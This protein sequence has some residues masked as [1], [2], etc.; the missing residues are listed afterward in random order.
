VTIVIAVVGGAGGVYITKF[1][2]TDSF[3]PGER[4]GL[5]AAIFTAVMSASLLLNALG[6]ALEPEKDGAK[7]PAR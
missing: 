4:W 5:W 7:K 6:M 1:G 3:V 2:N